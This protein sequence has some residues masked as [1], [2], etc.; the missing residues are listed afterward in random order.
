MATA[1]EIYLTDIKH[2]GDMVRTSQGNLEKVSGLENAYQQLFHR[3]ITTKG[4]VVHR[5]NYG[6]GAKNYQNVTMTLANQRALA[7]EI[8]DQFEQDER[9]EEVTG[10]LFETE[11]LE[12]GKFTVICRVKLVGYGEQSLEFTPFE[13]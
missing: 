2:K 10:V 1:V 7:L 4:A 9:V 5:P 11:D 8:K 6:V 13:G 3:L 12:A